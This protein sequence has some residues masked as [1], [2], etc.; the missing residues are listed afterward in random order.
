[1]RAEVTVRL[2]SNFYGPTFQISDR[3]R[4]K[5]FA[6]EMQFRNHV[7]QCEKDDSKMRS[8]R[9]CFCELTSRRIVFYRLSFPRK[10]VVEV[11]KTLEVMEETVKEACTP[12]CSA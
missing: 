4:K 6:G 5:N 8:Q 1:M 7:K 2:R 11:D 10:R 12:N 9:M 3:M